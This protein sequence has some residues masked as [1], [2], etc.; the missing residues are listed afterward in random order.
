LIT[1]GAEDQVDQ[2][3]RGQKPL[4]LLV[5]FEPTEYLLPFSRLSVRYFNR[6]VEAFVGAV[7]SV[8]CQYF[9]RLD[10]AAQF[11][12]DDAPWFAKL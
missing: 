6:I 12:G 11:I 7:V 4:S 10:I 5:R 3:M 2:V 8:R 9:D 1:A